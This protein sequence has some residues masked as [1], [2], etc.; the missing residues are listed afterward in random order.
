MYFSNLTPGVTRRPRMAPR[1]IAAK[2]HERDAIGR[3]GWMSCQA[4]EDLE[5]G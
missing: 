4:H 3:S 2:E 5:A 1:I